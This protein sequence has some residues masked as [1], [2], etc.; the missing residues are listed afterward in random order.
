MS[1]VLVDSS[2]W[3]AHFRQSNEMLKKLLLNDQVATHPLVILEI[4]CGTPPSPRSEIL[5]D[6]QLLRRVSVSTQGETLALLE[7][8]KLYGE[9]CGA[10][11]VSLLSSVLITP[12]ALLWTLDKKL[13]KLAKFCGVSFSAALH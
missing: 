2:V 8:R 10:V 7:N 12:G 3:M 9:G 4:A 11:D 6:L 5:Q 13:A 1:L